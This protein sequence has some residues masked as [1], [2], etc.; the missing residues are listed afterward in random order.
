MCATCFDTQH[1]SF[2]EAYHTR[3][4][5]RINTTLIVLAAYGTLASGPEPAYHLVLNLKAFKPC[6]TTPLCFGTLPPNL[7]RSGQRGFS[8][9]WK[10]QK[11]NGDS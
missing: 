10:P 3:M 4:G 11:Q 9:Q 5:L 2:E 8:E 1:K 6:P 7:S